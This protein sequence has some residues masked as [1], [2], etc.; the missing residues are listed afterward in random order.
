MQNHEPLQEQFAAISTQL[1]TLC[2]LY[3]RINELGT[4]YTPFISIVKLT[5]VGTGTTG[6]GPPTKTSLVPT[7]ID[8]FEKLAECQLNSSWLPLRNQRRDWHYLD[9]NVWRNYKEAQCAVRY[10]V[11]GGQY[12]ACEYG[13]P[14]STAADARLQILRRRS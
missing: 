12:E 9:N 2:D 3:A 13:D 8:F 10:F 5:L 7:L 14:R 1:Q 6:L 4:S 11:L